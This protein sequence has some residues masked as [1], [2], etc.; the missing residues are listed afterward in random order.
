MRHRADNQISG[1]AGAAVTKEMAVDLTF[2]QV[3]G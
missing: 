1:A 2:G 3:D